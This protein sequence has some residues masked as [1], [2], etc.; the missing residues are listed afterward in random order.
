MESSE[1]EPRMT[2]RNTVFNIVKTGQ[3]LGPGM[4]LEETCLLTR[5]QS[6]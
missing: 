1:S 5:W 3:V 2:R 4:S 6:A